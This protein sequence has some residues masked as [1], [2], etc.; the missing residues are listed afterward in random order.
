MSSRFLVKVD[1]K[2]VLNQVEGNMGKKDA[3]LPDDYVP[4]L[5]FEWLTAI[6][7]PVV[8]LTTRDTFVKRTL[9]EE[10]ELG[11]GMKVLDIASGTGT[12]SLMIKQHMGSVDV[13]G[14]DGDPKVIEIAQAKAR[15]ANVRVA[16][17]QA[18]ATHLPYSDNSYHRVVS[19][20]F[21]HHLKRPAKEEALA[22]A[23]RVLKPGG[24]LVIA[25]WGKPTGTMMR[26]LFYPIQ[27]LDG[28]ETTRDNVEGRL[29]GL[30]ED[31]G[32][33]NVQIRKSINTV[34]G[35]LALCS[36]SKN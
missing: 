6:Y 22:Q 28:F 13:T 30:I 32:F 27:W 8:Q 12:L 9:I 25:D 3:D 15:A 5:G 26:L 16:F 14:V 36:A 29:P 18:L 34:F 7:D 19:T 35:T 2:S 33:D 11:D 20:L 31:A 4:A 1:D 24:K 17:D 21:F 23:F 10:A